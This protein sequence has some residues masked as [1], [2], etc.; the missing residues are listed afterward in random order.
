[1]I[2]SF[3]FNNVE[4]STFKLVCKSVKRPLL[5]AAKLRRID[6]PGISGSYDFDDDGQEYSLRTITMKIQYIGTS[7]EELRTRA[8]QIAA[9]LST[10][11][12]AQL[13]M[14]DEEDKY[15]L[16]KVTSAI[17]LENLWESGSADI[18]FD[19]QPFAYS[20]ERRPQ[21]ISVTGVDDTFT[22][23]GTR[24]INFKSPQGSK[25]II[26]ILGSWQNI[27]I[28]MNGKSLYYG[29]SGSGLLIIDNIEMEVILNDENKF[30]V[31][32]GDIDTFLPIV[33]GENT[34]LI[35]GDSIL[36]EISIEY[37]PL[38]M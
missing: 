10:Q 25:S 33:P 22:N 35:S 14:H 21:W 20:N 15:Y 31:I 3:I 5:P 2:G 16:A 23:L 1:M 26:K 24:R 7:Y 19:C 32:T 27:G 4:S 38:W 13:K 30:S 37:I 29:E 9:W 36:V 6:P 11:S 28:G 18:E 12:W 17:D 8:R 34:V